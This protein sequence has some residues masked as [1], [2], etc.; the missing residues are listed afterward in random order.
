MGDEQACDLLFLLDG[1]EQVKDLFPCGSIQRGKRLITDQ[2][3]RLRDQC[4]GDPDP[5]PLS[6]G[7]LVRVPVCILRGKPCHTEHFLHSPS[8]LC[9]RQPVFPALR[10]QSLAKSLSHCQA[11]IEGT[12][13]ILE[14]HLDL[15]VPCTLSVPCPLPFPCIQTFS[16]VQDLPVIRRQEP[17]QEPCQSCLPAAALPGKGIDLPGP[18]LHRD[19]PDPLVCAEHLCHVLQAEKRRLRFPPQMS[20]LRMGW[21][22]LMPFRVP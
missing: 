21:N 14:H 20:L 12:I 5:L 4:P 22:R 3:L 17:G 18:D 7:K 10:P 2:K 19:V 1:Q 15:S 8:P 11:G 9:G 16:S 6:P 13:C